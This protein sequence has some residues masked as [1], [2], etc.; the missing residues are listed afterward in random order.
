M[1]EPSKPTGGLGGCT[2]P[3]VFAGAVAADVP[4]AGV[5]GDARAVVDGAG[6][7]SWSRWD[8]EAPALGRGVH[9]LAAAVETWLTELQ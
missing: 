1:I 7:R 5:A 8:A 6:F 3:E 2:V 9:D 4:A